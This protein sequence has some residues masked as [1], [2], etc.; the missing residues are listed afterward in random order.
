MIITI[1][2]LNSHHH[3]AEQSNLSI[4]FGRQCDAKFHNEAK[5]S[6]FNFDRE[7]VSENTEYYIADVK[8]NEELLQSHP[9][10]Q[11]NIS[12]QKHLAALR[13]HASKVAYCKL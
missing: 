11:P 8:Q 12:R 3:G 6:V 9:D 5:I 1:L 13:N 7:K 10:Y 2:S 4:D